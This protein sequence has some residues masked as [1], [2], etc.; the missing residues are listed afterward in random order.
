VLAG[1]HGVED[2]PGLSLWAGRLGGSATPFHL[3]AVEDGERWRIE[4]LPRVGEASSTMILLPDPFTFP[5]AEFVA[6][7]GRER[8][9]LAII[10]GLASAARQAGGNRLVIGGRV[11]RQGAVGVL[12]DTPLRPETVVSQGCRPIGQPF[13]VTRAERNVIFELGGRPALERL[14]ELVSSLPP[15]EQ[16]LAT[17][18][19]HCGIVVDEHQLEFTRGDFLIRGVLGADQSVGAIAVGEE[20][21]IGSTV[22]FQVRDASTAGEDLRSLLGGHTGDGALV[23][24]CNGRGAFMFGDADHDAR[25]V[26]DQLATSAVAGMFCA[27]EIGPV[28]GRNALHGFTA[29][30]ALFND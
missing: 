14:M 7:V 30:V 4:G 11:V 12:L 6:D 24:T 29:S 21:A 23:F 10:G 22:Q 18:G 26:S 1:A 27:G 13:T 25:I 5:L 9:G 16:A 3:S 15:D 8:P 2:A 17:Q 19:V 28:A 20:V